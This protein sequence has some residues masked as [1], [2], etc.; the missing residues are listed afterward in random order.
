MIGD[1]SNV[2]TGNLAVRFLTRAAILP[3]SSAA[4]AKAATLQ[5]CLPYSIDRFSL[6]TG[7]AGAVDFDF[8]D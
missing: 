2:K 3:N 1:L 6:R 5:K 7:I 4:M 8:L